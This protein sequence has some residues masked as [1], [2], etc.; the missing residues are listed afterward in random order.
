MVNNVSILFKQS[1]NKDNNSN[2]ILAFELVLII[3]QSLLFQSNLLRQEKLSNITRQKLKS[4]A[5][6]MGL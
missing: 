2:R 3:M 1:I 4:T 5:K 6:S